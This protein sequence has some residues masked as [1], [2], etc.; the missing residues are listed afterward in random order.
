MVL[1]LLLGKPV[2]HFYS[3]HIKCLPSCV[4]S[5]YIFRKADN[6]R[7]KYYLRITTILLVNLI[8]DRVHHYVF[9]YQGHQQR[10]LQL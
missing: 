4:G 8:Q 5:N 3:F 9:Y 10:E 1:F 6:D 7:E 2:R